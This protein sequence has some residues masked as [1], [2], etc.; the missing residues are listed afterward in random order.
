VDDEFICKAART[1]EEAKMLVEAGFKYVCDF[2]GVKLF[3]KQR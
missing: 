1:V 2:G 3:R